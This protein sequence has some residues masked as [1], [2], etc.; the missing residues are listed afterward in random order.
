MDTLFQKIKEL[1]VSHLAVLPTKNIRFEPSLIT[2]C[3]ANSCGNYGK[4]WTCPPLAGHTEALIAKAKSFSSALIFQKIYPLEDS[5]DIEGMAAGSADF[6]HV[7]QKALDIANT[8]PCPHLVL[9]A[10]GC[11]RCKT[12]AAINGLPCRFPDRQVA[13]LE[14]YSIQVSSLAE[15]CGMQYING[16]NTVT[17]FGGIFY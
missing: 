14:S 10:G 11:R 8:L 3:K 5:F 9:G 2:L 6:Q 1:G 7:I 16:P 12:C 4:N 15:A 13:S 17:Y